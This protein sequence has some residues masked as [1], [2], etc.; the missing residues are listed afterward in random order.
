MCNIDALFPITHD[1]F[2]GS[3]KFLVVYAIDHIVY[4]TVCETQVYKH[5][6]DYI[7]QRGKSPS[8]KSN[9]FNNCKGKPEEIGQKYYNQDHSAGFVKL[10]LLLLLLMLLIYSLPL[11]PCI[12]PY[13]H[14]HYTICYSNYNQVHQGSAYH[15][16]CILLKYISIT[17]CAIHTNDKA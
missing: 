3:P 15:Q 17:D 9:E 2:V 1:L 14:V 5:K 16:S 6:P 12:S 4:E 8:C 11:L 13:H 10:W 7:S